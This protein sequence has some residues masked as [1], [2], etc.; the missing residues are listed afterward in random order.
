MSPRKHSR[1]LINYEHTPRTQVAPTTAGPAHPSFAQT[2][3]KHSLDIK[4]LSKAGEAGV[5][6]DHLVLLH[7]DVAS[8]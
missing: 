5:C 6:D 7:E 4:A 3:S 8:V 2:R 1:P